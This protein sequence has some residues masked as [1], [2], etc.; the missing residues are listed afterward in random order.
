MKRLVAILCLVAPPAMAAPYASVTVLD[1]ATN[2]TSTLSGMQFKTILVENGGAAAVYCS[3]NPSVTTDTGHKVGANDG[4]RSF[5]Y[6][7]P[8]YCIAA[9]S[10]SGTGRSH[11]MVWGSTQ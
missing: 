9:A 6:D 11:V 8:I 10:Q 2:V 7:G 1:S 5:P 3:A 4:F